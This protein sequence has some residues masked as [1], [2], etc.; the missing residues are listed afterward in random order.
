MIEFNRSST[1][2]GFV[3]QTGAFTLI[4]LLVVIAIIAILAGMLLPALAKAK[5]KAQGIAC[6]NN[7]QQMIKALILYSMDYTD[8]LV[9]NPDDGN[10]TPGFNW[11]PGEAG[12]GMADEFNADILRDPSRSMLAPYIGTSAQIFKCPADKRHGK[13]HGDADVD[14]SKIGTDV[15]AARTFS[16]SQAVGTNPYKTGGKIAVDGPW[17]DGSHNHTVGKTWYTYGNTSQ[18]L[19]PGASK[20][21]IF[22]DEDAHS[23]N[24]GGFATVGPNIIPL[25]DM[26]DWPGWYHNGAC[27]FAFADGHSEIK[28]W[29][30]PRTLLTGSA[31]NQTQK[32]N[33]DISWMSVRSSALINGP[34][35]N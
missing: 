19:R 1:R 6:M 21:L 12:V 27:G 20:T 35:F 14:V 7:G 4:E 25:Y 9:P 2:Q 5:T 31:S 17:L 24:D 23:L 18:F 26:I 13:Y 11:C 16:M 15:P 22:L 30:D 32:G 8:Y 3:K 28:K 33:P 10:T 29:V 34:D